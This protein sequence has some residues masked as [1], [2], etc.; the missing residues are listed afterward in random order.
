MSARACYSTEFEQEETELTEKDAPA[1]RQKKDQPS[2][3]SLIKKSDTKPLLPPVQTTTRRQARCPDANQQMHLLRELAI[4][5]LIQV[6]I[7]V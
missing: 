2:F 7:H 5:R 4:L 6:G 3:Q 1:G